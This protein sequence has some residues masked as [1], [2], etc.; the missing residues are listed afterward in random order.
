MS[1]TPITILRIILSTTLLSLVGSF[2]VAQD[3][4]VEPG[5]E[6]TPGY[7]PPGDVASTR[8][9]FELLTGAGG[10]NFT[11]RQWYEFFEELQI[12]LQIRQAVRETEPSI[13]E[14]VRNKVRQIH[15]VAIVE[16]DG[17][18]KLP[19]GRVKLSQPEK[20][21][22]WIDG[23][24]EYG[25]QGDPEGKPLWGLSQAQYDFVRSSLAKEVTTDLKGMTFTKG[26]VSLPLGEDLPVV[27]TDEAKALMREP[28]NREQ[29]F[30]EDLR[31]I[32]LGSSLAIFLRDFNLSFE[33]QRLPNGMVVLSIQ[34]LESAETPWPIG[35]E[36]EGYPKQIAP[37]FFGLTTIRIQEF[38]LTKFIEYIEENTEI[39]MVFDTLA[40]RVIQLDPDE[41]NVTIRP[42]K[43]AWNLLLNKGLIPLRMRAERRLDEAGKPFLWVVP[44]ST[45]TRQRLKEI[46][47]GNDKQPAEPRTKSELG[48]EGN[49]LK[50]LSA[51]SVPE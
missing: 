7:I 22:T 42:D 26:L 35:W 17:S 6:A 2:A 15:V 47:A 16:T 44:T 31:G 29:K 46:E 30:S 32:S 51:P 41:I 49:V 38:T 18:L 3:S 19:T 45:L 25:A 20:L 33:P 1:T 10:Q 24:R 28:E 37:S 11:A 40:F 27:L 36:W 12:P 43:T 23:L 21:K 48:G 13:S 5:A 8:I 50:S 34:L 39:P 14:E 4:L 9:S